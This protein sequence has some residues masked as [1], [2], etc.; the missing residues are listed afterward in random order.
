MKKKILNIIFVII[1]LI[2]IIIALS[3]CGKKPSD[4]EFIENGIKLYEQEF[5]DEFSFVRMVIDENGI[6]GDFGTLEEGN[7]EIIVTSKK[8]PNKEIEMSF[9]YNKNTKKYRMGGSNYNFVRY[10][11]QLYKDLENVIQIY[12]DSFI[13]ISSLGIDNS[14]LTYAEYISGNNGL[15]LNV[16]VAPGQY[17]QKEDARK[18]VNILKQNGIAMS[19]I[20]IWYIKTDDEYL[21]IKNEEYIDIHGLGGR[22]YDNIYISMGEPF[23]I[24]CMDI[25]GRRV[26]WNE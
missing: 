9:F 24:D 5:N 25:N 20:G 6:W 16:Y 1:I 17:N 12:P 2:G 26:E 3:G 21:R 7:M 4:E 11:E 18:L 23:E 19:S 10:E 14:D 15:C 13:R 22:D 8:Y